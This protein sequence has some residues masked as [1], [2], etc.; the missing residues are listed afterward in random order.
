MRS[1]HEP[2]ASRH[3]EFDPP[4][5]EKPV[6]VRS[7]HGVLGKTQF[8][9]KAPSGTERAS[10]AMQRAMTQALKAQDQK[11]AHV[12]VSSC[13]SSPEGHAG[14]L[15]SPVSAWSNTERT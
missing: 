1:R 5:R 15:I 8:G 9:S 10:P 4:G 13:I 3:R 6:P 12:N 11:A 2:G 7:M 14:S